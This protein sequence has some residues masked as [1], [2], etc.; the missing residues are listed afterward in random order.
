MLRVDPRRDPFAAGAGVPPSFVAGRGEL[1]E[2]FEV[3]L[4]RLASGRHAVGPL[5]TGPT[6]TG[7]TVLLNLYAQTA[8]ERGWF[9]ASEEVNPSTPL[10][11]LIAAMAYEVLL[12]MSATKRFVDRVQRALGVLKAFTSVSALGIGVTID[13]TALSGTADSGIFDR[14]LRRLFIELGET[15]QAHGTGVLFTL[16]E[17]HTL[18][19]P[20][21]DALNSALHQTAQRT[22]PVLLAS[23]GL[24][25][26]WQNGVERRNPFRRSSYAAR[27]NAATYIRLEPLRPEAAM[28]ALANP[29][30]QAGATITDQALSAAVDFA[31]GNPW[32][33]Q[34]VGSAMWQAAEAS[35]ISAEDVAR[36]ERGVQEQLDS[37]YLPRLLRDCARDELA[38]LGQVASEFPPPVRLDDVLADCNREDRERAF[39]ILSRLAQRD[40][41]ECNRDEIV[42]FSV[43]RLRTYL[44]SSWNAIDWREERPL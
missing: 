9:V 14:D 2:R 32:L 29:V 15:A 22:L 12:E 38:F 7:K 21:L 13:A 44:E 5:L 17:M 4:D 10:S 37:W 24:F 1:I 11:G 8:K 36:A 35:T 20:E 27:A 34:L 26:S 41:V 28:E 6:G 19:Q 23:A 25:P 31:E 39:G 16:D 40:L 33:L 3:A 30:R 42:R 18:G 43:P